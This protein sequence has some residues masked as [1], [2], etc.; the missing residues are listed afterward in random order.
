ML[1]ITCITSNYSPALIS[2]QETRNY[3][4]K[5]FDDY[6]FI[7]IKEEKKR[8]KEKETPQTHRTSMGLTAVTQGEGWGRTLAVGQ[9]CSGAGLQHSPCC[10]GCGAVSSQQLRCPLQ[11]SH[12]PLSAQRWDAEGWRC[13]DPRRLLDGRVNYPCNEQRVVCVRQG[14][15]KRE[16]KKE[17]K[18]RISV[19]RCV[20]DW[21]EK[22]RS[23]A[24]WE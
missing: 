2:E 1:Q 19:L 18:K 21:G 7:L 11:P 10:G 23:S 12:C 5:L 24:L 16:R 20:G 4:Q 22:C 17:G 3:P 13:G 14:G 8:K 9:G 6:Y 15:R